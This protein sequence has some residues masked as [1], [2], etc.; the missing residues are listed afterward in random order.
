MKT[1]CIWISLT[2]AALQTGRAQSQDFPGPIEATGFPQ[3][4]T[5]AL[6]VEPGSLKA[7]CDMST[8]IVEGL[9]TTSLTPRMLGIY[10]RTL[11][12]DAIIT[13]TRTLKGKASNSDIVI[14]QRGGTIGQFTLKPVDYDIV[15]PGEQYLLFLK[16]DNR[17]NIPQISGAKRYF[18]IG[19]WSGL[20]YF[21]GGKMQLQHPTQDFRKD[22]GGLSEGQVINLVTDAINKPAPSPLP[23]PVTITK[24]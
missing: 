15:Q 22:F 5:A 17:P 4:G 8:L 9:V 19:A 23:F 20:F 14:S 24:P 1:V 10:G 12:T 21:N 6:I 18:V 11:E 2:S 3:R 7:L 16:D 13:V